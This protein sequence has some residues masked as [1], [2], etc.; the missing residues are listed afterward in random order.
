MLI[1]GEG[2]GTVVGVC[3]CDCVCVGNLAMSRKTE[4]QHRSGWS[5]DG[6]MKGDMP[7]QKHLYS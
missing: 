2:A 3:A 6:E 7:E 5:G 1:W 4:R